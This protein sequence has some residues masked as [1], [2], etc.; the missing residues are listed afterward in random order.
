MPRFHLFNSLQISLSSLH[1]FMVLYFKLHAHGSLCWFNGFQLL[2]LSFI[3]NYFLVF[4]GCLETF[5]SDFL[6]ICHFKIIETSTVLL[7]KSE[8]TCR[9]VMS[10]V[11]PP[12]KSHFSPTH[13]C[14]GR[15]QCP[16]FHNKLSVGNSRA[17]KP[18][19]ASASVPPFP[20]L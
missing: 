13:S 19:L 10:C 4:T 3:S 14:D 8:E 12:E 2:L 7:M 6:A 5:T 17:L 11:S 18:I 9:P 15:V 1:S 16:R 20:S